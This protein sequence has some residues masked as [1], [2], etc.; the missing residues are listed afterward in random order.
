MREIIYR[1]VEMMK[2]LG[3]ERDALFGVSA[4]KKSVPLQAR[5][6]REGFKRLRLPDFKTVGT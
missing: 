2:R 6:G 3:S 5:T 4:V 1:L